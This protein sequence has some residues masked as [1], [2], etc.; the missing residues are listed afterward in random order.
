MSARAPWRRPLWRRL[1]APV[2]LPLRRW[3]TRAPDAV[4]VGAMDDGAGGVVLLYNVVNP[5]HDRFGS[6]VGAASLRLMGL[7][8]PVLRREDMQ[9]AKYTVVADNEK[10]VIIRDEGPWDAHLTVTN[11]AE[12]VVAALAPSLRG[13]RLLYVD[14]DGDMDELVV[15]DGKFVGFAAGPR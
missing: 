14:S 9:R 4:Y 13:R 12:A 7:R 6:T 2:V 5:W 15:R 3:L 11:D 10:E 8:A 1:L